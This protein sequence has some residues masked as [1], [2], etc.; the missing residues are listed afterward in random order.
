MC[1]GQPD[2]L[3]PSQSAADQHRQNGAVP[4]PLIRR[5]IR[6]RQQHLGLALGEPVASAD[7]ALF[8]AADRPDRLR[9]GC[10]EQPLCLAASLRTA[11]SF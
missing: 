11:E 1:E 4:F 8:R 10:I 9:R 2:G 3:V 7:A 5:P 6:S